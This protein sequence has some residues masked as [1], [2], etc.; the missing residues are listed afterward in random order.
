MYEYLIGVDAQSG[1]FIPQL[2]TEWNVEP[3]GKSYRFKLRQGVQFQG[4]WGQF[5]AKDVEFS[6]R[7]IM[8]EDSQ[9][10]NAGYFRGLID[11]IDIVSDYEVVVRLKKP[12]A[13]FLNV[14]GELV[15]GVEMKSK[16]NYDAEGRPTL[17]GKP[18][19]GTGA[20]QFK[21]R[22]QG[23][24]IRFER[25]PYQHWRIQPEFQELELRWQKEAST[26]LASLLAGEVHVTTL[27][28][29]LIVEAQ[30]QGMTT[31]AGQIQSV[32][33]FGSFH[34]CFKS[35]PTDAS[36]GY[37]YPESPLMDVRV[38]RA[39][40]KAINRDEMN[41]AFFGGKAETMVL[42]HFTKERLGWNPEWET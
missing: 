37:M 30:K 18:T 26:R 27:P 34:C 7:N 14:S 21:E 41:R 9:H 33:T 1:K 6:F 32:R 25:V 16:A 13:D 20:Y 10:G 17:T 12:D 35:D 24:Y 15:S 11:G 38:R 8:E 23:S 19:A 2:A 42:N 40:N 22:V 5:T 29:D 39:L 28:Q 31:Q 3:D 36:K 4:G